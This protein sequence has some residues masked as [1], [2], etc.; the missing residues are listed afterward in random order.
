[1]PVFLAA[2]CLA[3]ATDLKSRTISKGFLLIFMLLGILWRLFSKRPFSETLLAM[4]P[5]AVLLLFSR[6]TAGEIGEGDGWFFVVSGL[7]LSWRE[8]AVLFLSGLMLCGCSFLRPGPPAER[9]REKNGF[10]SCRSC[11]PAES[12]S[13]FHKGKESGTGLQRQLYDR[14]G[15]GAS[16]DFSRSCLFAFSCVPGS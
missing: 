11:F 7:F 9:T 16:G 12:G 10:R 1:M 15:T 3:A 14:G 4:L 8:A 2:L 13:F 6:I 5:G